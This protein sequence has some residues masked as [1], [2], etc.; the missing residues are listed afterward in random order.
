MLAGQLRLA[1]TNALTP[2]AR[3]DDVGLDSLGLLSFIA[4]MEREFGISVSDLDYEG[5]TTFGDVVALVER[6][7]RA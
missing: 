2:G 1:D 3:L 7:T 4:A 5:L 6:L